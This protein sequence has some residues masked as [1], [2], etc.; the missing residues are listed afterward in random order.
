[1]VRQRS[2]WLS[3]SSASAACGESGGQIARQ[4]LG[5]DRD[6]RQRRAELMRRRRSQATD[7]RDALLARQ[8]E[9]S[10]GIGI[11]HPARFERDRPRIAGDE[12]CRAHQRRPESQDIDRCRL[13][14]Q[15]SALRQRQ[16]PDGQHADRDDGQRRKTDHRRARQDGRRHDHRRQHQDR[17]GIFESA[18]QEEQDA[19]LQ[20]VVGEIGSRFAIAEPRGRQATP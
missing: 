13:E 16:M 11:A 9:L 6:R 12:E 1:M 14:G 3:S 8:S 4:F 18:G 2:L 19:E 15:Q 17:E 7:R 10:R 20:R 5:D